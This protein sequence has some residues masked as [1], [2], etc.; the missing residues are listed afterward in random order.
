MQRHVKE[1]GR[2]MESVWD[3]AQAI[4]AIARDI[5]HQDNRIEIERRAGKLLDKVAA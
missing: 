3:A 5:P 1:E 4:T 2:P